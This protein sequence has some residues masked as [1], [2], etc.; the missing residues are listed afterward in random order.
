MNKTK[1]EWTDYTWNPVVGCKHGCFYCYARDMNRRFKWVLDWYEPQ[2]FPKRLEKPLNINKPSKIFVGSMCDLFGEWIPAE[3]IKKIINITRKCPQH[4][5]QFLTK[6]PMRYLEFKF[7]ENCW[8]GHT[9]DKYTDDKF[10]GNEY[11]KEIPSVK[12]ISFEP[13]LSDMSGIDLNGIDWV[14][15]GAMTGPNPIKP[16]KEWIEDVINLAKDKNI[17][18]FLKGNLCWSENI[19]EFPIINGR[20]CQKL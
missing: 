9:I 4:T 10:L 3:W 5:F 11:L 2:I 16:N 12:F 8:L 7:P 6:N 14:I 1:I 17:P 18:L 19:Q 20:E 13:L 15:V